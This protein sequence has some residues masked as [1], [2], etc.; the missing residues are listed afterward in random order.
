MTLFTLQ[1][2]T[3][4]LSSE[5]ATQV[6]FLRL[7]PI[8]NILVHYSDGRKEEHKIDFS[9]ARL[10]S[11]I[12]EEKRIVRLV[13]FSEF[14]QYICP[15]DIAAYQGKINVPQLLTI[16][17][18]SSQLT[19]ELIKQIRLLHLSSVSDI[20][21]DYPNG[22]SRHYQIDVSNELDFL[23]RLNPNMVMNCF[24]KIIGTFISS[25]EY[26]RFQAKIDFDALDVYPKENAQELDERVKY[27]HGREAR[28]F[29]NH[30]VECVSRLAQKENVLPIPCPLQ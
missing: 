18:L 2:L 22:K 8:C 9:D 7:T 26:A 5:S 15:E 19:P 11:M 30:R 23:S 20:L 27:Q 4:H 25:E 14:A 10:E 29:I 6:Q 12:E 24:K 21:I 28:F 1:E 16:K 17:R 13:F 3:L